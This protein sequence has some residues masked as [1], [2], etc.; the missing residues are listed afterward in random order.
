[1]RFTSRLVDSN[2]RCSN[3]ND[4]RYEAIWATE[5]TKSVELFLSS[6]ASVTGKPNGVQ[7]FCGQPGSSISLVA[8][9]PGGSDKASTTLG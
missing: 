1:L 2:I 7:A 3:R 5:N 9:G 4:R 6:G 8:N